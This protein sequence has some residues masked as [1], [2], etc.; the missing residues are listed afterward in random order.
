MAGCGS[1]GSGSTPDNPCSKDHGGCDVHATCSDT[2]GVATCSCIPGY[3]GNGKTCK[4]VQ[5]CDTDN[6]PCANNATCTVENGAPK[7]TCIDGYSGDGYRCVERPTCAKKRGGC[8][9]NA[10]CD[11]SSGTVLCVCGEKYEGDGYTCVLKPNCDDPPNQCPE[12]SRCSIVDRKVTCT[13]EELYVPTPE[14]TCRPQDNCVAKPT[15]CGANTVCVPTSTTD[16]TKDPSCNCVAGT[17]K[18]TGSTR[19]CRPFKTCATNACGDHSKCTEPQFMDGLPTGDRT[20]ACDLGYASPTND[21]LSCEN[22]NECLTNNGGC[23]TNSTCTDIPGTNT[24]ACNAGYRSPSGSNRDCVQVD[25]CDPSNNPCDSANSTCNALAP[26]QPPE[27]ICKPGWTGKTSTGCPV[28]VDRCADNTH[29]CSAATS[30]CKYEG[31]GTFSCPCKD[32]YE[33]QTLTGCTPIDPCAKGTH[34]CDLT[35]S[36]CKYEGPGAFSCTCKSGYQHPNE[37]ET[38]LCNDINECSVQLVSTHCDKNSTCTNKPGTWECACNDGFFGTG[39]YSSSGPTCNARYTKVAVGE[40]HACAVREDAAGTLVCWGYNKSGQFG[41][42]QTQSCSSGCSPTYEPVKTN[43]I[44]DGSSWFKIAA[45]G[46][47]TCGVRGNGALYCWGGNTYGQLGDGTKNPTSSPK[48]IAAGITWVDVSVEWDH[49]CA[50]ASDGQ[51]Y[52]WGQGTQGQLG[53]DA[54]V[55]ALTPS[56]TIPMVSGETPFFVASAVGALNQSCAIDSNPG[57]IWCW[58]SNSTGQAALG[59]TNFVQKPNVI[60]AAV[61]SG[62]SAQGDQLWSRLAAGYG[63]TCGI[64]SDGSAWCWGDNTKG[65]L[66]NK[67]FQSKNQP[68]PVISSTSVAQQSEFFWLGPNNPTVSTLALGDFHACGIVSNQWIA[69]WGDNGAG[70]LGQGPSVSVSPQNAAAAIVI[71]SAPQGMGFNRIAAKKAMTCAISEDPVSMGVPRSD[72][73]QRLWCWGTTPTSAVFGYGSTPTLIAR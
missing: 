61:R 60:M 11:D 17:T 73:D 7:C 26:G 43:A 42:G 22:V 59:S 9:D 35:D 71:P 56:P 36:T 27:C 4:P 5:Y 69:C 65:Q 51:T 54:Q 14:Q 64:Q 40:E 20:C 46:Q 24:C 62:G 57:R 2:T 63:S 52:C 23:G 37:T 1:L 29:T 10:E 45:G 47:T 72:Y 44:A 12:N 28:P 33:N 34:S 70:Q 48:R 16:L 55:Q 30:T 3:T 39:L 41:N 6:N 32:G 15:F 50:V 25:Q 67:S 19:I 31:P 21:G 49:T 18:E 8:D 38:K 58:G 68:S 53:N 13:C 66:G